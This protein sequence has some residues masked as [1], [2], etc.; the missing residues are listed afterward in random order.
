M[1]KYHYLRKKRGGAST[2]TTAPEIIHCGV[3]E[4]REEKG[5]MGTEPLH[6]LL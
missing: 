1:L 4:K 3:G 6:F 5:N 2:L